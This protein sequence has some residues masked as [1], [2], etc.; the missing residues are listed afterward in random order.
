VHWQGS[1]DASG[2]AS[3]DIQ[4]RNVPDGTWND[5]LKGAATSE[6]IFTP[7]TPGSYAFRIRAHDW[8][9]HEEAWRDA[10][11]IVVKP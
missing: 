8:V 9:G 1:D 10:E 4:V 3:Y 5:W 6:D 2:V 7:S 11:D